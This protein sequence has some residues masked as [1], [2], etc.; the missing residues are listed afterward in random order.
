MTQSYPSLPELIDLDFG[1]FA[2]DLPLYEQR[3]QRSDGPILELGIGTGRV[4]LPLAQSGC[5]VWG[6]DHSAAMLEHARSKGA[7]DVISRLHLTLADMRDFTLD[8]KFALIFAGAGGFDHLVTPD[9]QARC[10]RRVR[11]HLLPGGLFVCDLRPVL[12]NSWELGASAPIFH[13]WT[14]ELP[15]HGVTVMKTHSV[16][17][18]AARQYQC[19][20]NIYDCLSAD[21]NVRRIV[22]EVDLRFTTRYEMEGLLRDAKLELDQVY[23][24]YDLAPYDSTSEYMITIA[25]RPEEPS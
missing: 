6:I 13:D 20:T 10:L 17:A 7:P 9:D 19:Q 2:D 12:H 15:E 16:R 14:R 11:D 22:D 21:G 18:D 24:D 25:R 5:E 8:Q 23:G 4:A 3:A 1:D